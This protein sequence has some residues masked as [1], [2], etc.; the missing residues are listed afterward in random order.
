MHRVLRRLAFPRGLRYMAV[1]AFF[2]SIMSLL[3]KLAGQRLPSQEMVLARSATMLGL[4]WIGL[5]RA[6]LSWLGA[7]HRSLLVIRGI[8]GFSA[9]DPLTIVAMGAILLAVAALA[10]YLP[11][12]RATR[13]DPL[14]ALR[15]E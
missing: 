3:V 1:G 13:V 5:R 6:G 11:A 10:S 4:S 8:F 15:P 7:R 2:F 14:I 9:L 12:R